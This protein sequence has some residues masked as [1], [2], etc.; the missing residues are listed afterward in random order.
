M[1]AGAVVNV[2]RLLG[3]HEQTRLVDLTGRGRAISGGDLP[4]FPA[5]N[6]FT[7]F[8]TEWRSYQTGT[9][10]VSAAAYIGYDFGQITIP[11]G[12]QRYGIDA[13]HREL[14]TAIKIKQSNDPTRRVTKVRVERS[15]DGAKWYGVAAI[16]IPNNNA[17]N[18]VSFKKSVPSR[19]WRL[20]PIGFESTCTAWAVQALELYDYSST[21]ISNIQDPILLEN[22]DRDYANPP[23]PIKGYYDLVAP[24][25]YLSAL[26]I[27][28]PDASYTVR[29]NFNMCV[30]VLGR[31]LVIGDIL[32]LPSETQYTPDLRPVKKY[33]EVT[34]VTWDAAS[35]TP[36]W[37]PTMLQ[38]TAS[39]ALAS[40]E[41]QDI[42]GNLAQTV[43]ASGLFSTDD[44]NH[45]QYQDYSAISHTIESTA[46]SQ[47]PER[48]SEGSNTIR[49]FE[50]TEI[51]TLQSAGV[52]SPQKLGLVRTGL[53]VED[54]MP[55][56][57]QPY[58]EGPTLPQG[59]SDGDYHRLTYE[60]LAKD[61]P[62]R[63]YRWSSTKQRWIYLETDKRQQYNNQKAGLAEYTTSPTRVPAREIR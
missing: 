42:F 41:T 43:D 39:P 19:F 14:V 24:N 58:T 4:G 16:D 49:E 18:V 7:T 1:I 17:L 63:L 29:V 20:R 62:A 28:T 30:G 6:A 47:V 8:A 60:G 10:A 33:L 48:G 45:S 11:N 22:R 55:Q 9:T 57:G 61:V 12:R 27:E 15:D 54:A 23:T 26:G 50:P 25:T 44:G 37:Q 34:D 46:A 52:P 32:E 38:I 51:A 59:A 56:N 40:Q 21:D 31:P 2:Y 13:A 53:Y 3:V 5:S 36:G 35:Y